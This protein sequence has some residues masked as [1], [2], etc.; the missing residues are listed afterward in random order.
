L[1]IRNSGT[2][3][4]SGH[5]TIDLY[6]ENSGPGKSGRNLRMVVLS[7]RSLSGTLL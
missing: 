3:A 5:T 1:I 2:F 6:R 4:L 7:N